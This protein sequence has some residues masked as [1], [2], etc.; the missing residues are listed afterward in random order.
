MPLKAKA[1]T[2]VDKRLKM[3]VYGSAGC[4][5]TT[6]SIQFP[7]PYIIDTEK[8]TENDGY[9]DLIN[10]SGGAVLKS[11][12][13]DEVYAEVKALLSEE[14]DYKTLVIDP[15]TT[16]YDDLLEK[17]AAKNGTEFGR[18]YNDAN[19][20][21]KSLVNLLLRLDMNLIVTSHAKNEYGQ[22]LSV[23]GQTFDCY[24]KIDYL[25]D[26]VLEVKKAADERIAIVKKTR[27]DKFIDGSRFTFSYDEIAKLYGAESLVKKAEA[28]ALAS[29]EQ[30]ARIHELIGIFKIADETIE[31]W[32][33]KAQCN[34]FEDM[35]ADIIQKCID[36]LEATLT[37][38]SD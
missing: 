9:V 19:K 26:L 7:K 15:L 38:R 21:M 6:A 24:K 22:N 32:F 28:Q 5:K 27:I 18:H 4:G 31:K 16:I 30:I 2:K 10:K 29:P 34:S 20:K 8:G 14:H 36:S 17:S 13:Y 33:T 23:I 3:F 35:S 11:C 37:K 1:P 12:D 25:F